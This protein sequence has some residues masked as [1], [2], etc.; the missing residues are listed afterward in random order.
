MTSKSILL[1]RMCVIAILAGIYTLGFIITPY[2]IKTKTTPEMI[3]ILALTIGI[4]AA[5]SFF[6]AKE[7]RLRLEPMQW[8]HFLILLAGLIV[9]NLKPLS[10]DI[11][12]R[13]DEGIHITRTLALASL[14]PIVWVFVFLI[15]FIATV[16]LAWRRSY[17]AIVLGILFVGGV[18][19]INLVNNPLA[20]IPSTILLRYPFINYWFFAFLPMAVIAVKAN[21]YQEVI[22]RMVPFLSTFALVWIF[23][24]DFFGSKTMLNLFWGMAVASMPLVY[25]YSSIL[26][27]ELPAIVLMLIVCI[28]I[29]SLLKEEPQKIRQNPAWYALILLGFIKETTIPFLMCF[30]GWRLIS[31]VFGGRVSIGTI[32]QFLHRLGG[33]LLTGMCVLL[34]VVFFLFLRGT[35]SQQSR[36]FSLTLVNLT[37]PVVYRTILQSFIEQL[38]YPFLLLFCGSC[39]FLFCKKEYSIAGFFLCLFFIYPAFFAVD[40]F[41]YT[42]YSR[43]NLFILPPVLAGS[44]ILLKRVLENRKIIGSITA[45]VILV[46]NLWTSPVYLDGTKKPLWGNA[47]TDTS[48][49]YYP[50]REALGWLKNNYGNESILFAGMYYPYPFDFYFGQLS[51]TPINLEYMT[52]YINSNSLSLSLAVAEAER[53]NIQ[54]VL[55]QVLGKQSP[56]EPAAGPLFHEEKIFRNEAHTLIVYTRKP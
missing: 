24:K 13:G 7:L 22:Y 6:S 40:T 19:S 48:E 36:W 17:W 31:S 38:G 37:K 27:I 25:Y 12:W 49:H 11:P 42:G 10:I 45:C 32:S 2:W 54:V 50:Y 16:T 21:P 15:V 26:Y 43:F 30:L 41:I 23:Q 3:F 14:I 33:E 5:W 46:I 39:I 56:N 29:P 18:I 47:L 51:W 52:R 44:S 34:P 9:L 8:G 20:R 35:Q 53:D 4:G 1:P 28:N 55:F